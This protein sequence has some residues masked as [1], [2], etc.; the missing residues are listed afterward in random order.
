MTK[1]LE[2]CC[3]L[4]NHFLEK[5]K[6]TWEEKQES[7]GYYQQASSLPTLKQTHPSLKIVY[8]Q[9]LQNVAMRIDLAFKAFFRR[10]KAGE[11]PGYPRFKGE[12]RYNS[13]TYPQY[14]NG[15]RIDGKRLF[16]SKIGY[17]RVVQL[18][19]IE[20]KVKTICICRSSTGKWFVNITYEVEPQRLPESTKNVGIDVGLKSFATLDD[21]EK[22]DNP[23]FFSEEEKN[24]AKANRRLSK[25]KKGSPEQEKKRKVVARVHERIANR[26]SNFAHQHSRKIINRY[27]IVAIEDLSVN[28]MVHNKCFSKSISDAAWSQFAQFLSYKAEEAGRTLVRVNPAYTSQD[29]SQC[30]H[31]QYKK[32]SDRMHRCSC[33]GLEL[34]RDVNAA[35]NILALG[36]QSLAQA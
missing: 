4:Y 23:R 31:R 22:I 18:N 25:E 20:G 2:E 11:K 15:C 3:W 26:R 1:T 13:F 19:S 21:G 33:C 27:N 10:V 17:L 8:S 5:R 29:C 36:L 32:L 12:G 35:R 14:G 24:L 28:Q 7:L 9:S 6:V 34:D 30:G 16:L